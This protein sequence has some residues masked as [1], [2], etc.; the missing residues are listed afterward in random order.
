MVRQREHPPPQVLLVS[1]EAGQGLRHVEE[2]LPEHVL[3]VAH[4]LAAEV[5]EHAS[6]VGPVD[7]ARIHGEPA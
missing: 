3:R 4:P 5:A 1:L 6:G 7:V 2:H